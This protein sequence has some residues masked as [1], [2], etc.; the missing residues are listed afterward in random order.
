MRYY[1]DIILDENIGDIKTLC[2]KGYGL[3]GYYAL[4][5]SSIGNG[6]MEILSFSDALKSVNRYKNYGV[7]AVVKG[8]CNAEKTAAKLIEKW[9]NDKGDI[10]NFKDYYNS[11]CR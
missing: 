11:R 8:R 10:D 4:C 5:V 9:I 3:L 2:D 6:I 7:L 1:E